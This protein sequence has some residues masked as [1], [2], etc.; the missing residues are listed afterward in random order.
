MLNPDAWRLI[1]V[2]VRPATLPGGVVSP[3]VP[4]GAV[5]DMVPV[6]S[7]LALLI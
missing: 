5:D 7:S 1:G 4:A 2:T 3:P 6:T